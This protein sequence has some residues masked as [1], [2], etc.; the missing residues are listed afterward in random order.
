MSPSVL[1]LCGSPRHAKSASRLAARYLAQFLDHDYELVDLARIK[2]PASPETA[3]APGLDAVVEKMRAAAAIVWVFGGWSW[4]VPHPIHRLFEDLFAHDGVAFEGKLAAAVMTSGGVGDDYI[5]ERVRFASEQLGLGYL[6]D[7][8]GLGSPILGYEGDAAGFEESCRVLAGQL[9]RALADGFVPAKM[10]P[11]LERRFLSATSRGQAFPVDGPAAAKTG[12]RT[13]AVVTGN[14]L[15]A[16]PAAASLVEAL[17]RYSTNRIETVELA[18]RKVGPCVGC[19]LCDFREAGICVLKDDYDAIHRRL[20]EVDAIVWAGIASCGLV[21]A[22]LKAFIDR[23]WG[24]A[25]RPT[26]IGK[27]G[28]VFASGGGPLD[29]DAAAHLD[30]VLT[31]MGA[32]CAARLAQSVAEPAAFGA[33]VRRAI[34]DLD[35]ALEEGWPHVERYNQR[36]V[37]GAFRDLA[38]KRGMVLKADYS[39]HRRHRLFDAPSPGGGNAI[40]RWL[41]K[42]EALQKKMLAKARARTDQARQQR[43]AAFLGGGGALGT[44][45][46]LSTDRAT[47][48]RKAN[49][50]AVS[51][52][53]AG[54]APAEKDTAPS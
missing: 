16:D 33:T 26:L 12:Q 1:F 40:L 35:R 51:P 14:R 49:A 54:E 38:A 20:H 4:F 30:G 36:A 28:L 22:R 3:R 8:S 39:F 24:I 48:D 15:S 9:N 37:R 23:G 32:R 44:G 19:F 25:H 7:V 43:Q 10:Y 11:S 53:P 47:R 27:H 52:E 2:L 29:V 42:S 21:D 5:L 6:G 31:K 13:I 50:V 45:R 34:E 46:D 17:H 18:D 41:C